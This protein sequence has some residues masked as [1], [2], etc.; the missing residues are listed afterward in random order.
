MAVLVQVVDSVPEDPRLGEMIRRTY[1]DLFSIFNL[2]SSLRPA[3]ELILAFAA[4]TDNCDLVLVLEKIPE[5]RRNL[6]QAHA[7]AASQHIHTHLATSLSIW[8]SAIVLPVSN[9]LEP[10]S[11]PGWD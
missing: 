8:I 9:A 11:W 2:P 3:S 1:P 6:Y 10:H 4:G 7:L 5:C